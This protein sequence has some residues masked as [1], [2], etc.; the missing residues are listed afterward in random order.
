MRE[1]VLKDVPV[2]K[3]NAMISVNE[4]LVKVNQ[5]VALE[6]VCHCYFSLS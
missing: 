4:A 1:T 5:S 3:G 2:E 6:R